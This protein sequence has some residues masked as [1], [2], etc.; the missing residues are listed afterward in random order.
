MDFIN[1]TMK[2]L[3]TSSDKNALQQKREERKNA[4]VAASND[5]I[6]ESTP[7]NIE[8]KNN[9]KD[10]KD[11]KKVVRDY[12][13]WKGFGTGLLTTFIMAIIIIVNGMALLYH[14]KLGVKLDPLPTNVNKLPY[15]PSPNAN[16]N[17]TL[18]YV[19]YPQTDANFIQLFSRMIAYSM[20]YFRKTLEILFMAFNVRSATTN[21]D[22]FSRLDYMIFI[23]GF[24]IMGALPFGLSIIGVIGAIVG[25]FEANSGIITKFFMLCV[26]FF[27][28]WGIFSFQMLYAFI[29]L[30]SGVYSLYNIKKMGLYF[31][32]LK[33]IIYWIVVLSILIP[34][35][36]TL[37]YPI[38]LGILAGVLMPYIKTLVAF[39]Y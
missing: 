2:N 37:W 36:S 24:I 23:V 3:S 28:L 15:N 31:N 32:N 5:N 17:D 14:T 20:S 22:T 35:S 39:F 9:T 16:L 26:S 18:P 8:S 27:V 33:H 38:T 29:F 11:K 1:N 30:I 19:N 21:P 10:N 13:D 7:A 34:A 6:Q 12:S 25:F 4:P